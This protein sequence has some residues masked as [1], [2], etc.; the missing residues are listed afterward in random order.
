MSEIVNDTYAQFVR[1]TDDDDSISNNHIRATIDAGKGNDTIDNWLVVWDSGNSIYNS[2]RKPNYASIYGG[3][4]N[5]SIRNQSDLSMVLG[6]DGNDTIDNW[7][8]GEL[9]SNDFYM[10]RAVTIDGGKGNDLI[11]NGGVNVT[12]N[13]GDGK[14]T[15]DNNRMNAFINSD[16]GND[17]IVNSDWG[18]NSTLLGGKGNDFI[19]NYADNI[20][21]E[22]G[23]GNDTINIATKGSVI[24]E[25]T[26]ES[27]AKNTL[28]KYKSGDGNDKII[29]FNATSTLRIG[30]G[31][32]TYSTVMSGDNIVVTVGKGKITL[33]GAA[34]LDELHIDGATVQKVTNSTKSPVVADAD[35]K[36]IDAS[37]RL[38]DIQITA[39]KLA[40][41][42]VGG[43]KNDSIYGGYGADTISGGKGNDRLYG[44]AGNDSLIGGE[45][46]DFI[47]GGTGKDKLLGGKGND[48]LDG[49]TGND[50]IDGG[51]NADVLSGGA[52][53][54][55]L[56][57]GKGNDSLVGDAGKD[58][59]YG[60]D[61]DDTIRG[62]AGDD[63]LWGGKGNDF[64][65]GDAGKDTF[66][67]SSG[68]GKD[69]IYGFENND[70]LKITGTFST[71]YD[72]SK[73]E[74]YFKV[75]NTS[76][77]IMLKDFTATTFNVNSSTYQISG[78]KLVK[79]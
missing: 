20:T 73:H 21:I 25:R 77:A 79:K 7:A 46:D 61:G 57:G 70:L 10:G 16:A 11:I 31:K 27:D 26:L 54:D 66:I 49:G 67:Y 34:D 60:Q 3:A 2:H 30:D 28:I 65:Y 42:I 8:S 15:V 41:S 63:S 59:L 45:G 17:S 48:T 78:S 37:K 74:V 29:G 72:S 56:R 58:K 18:N 50:S 24:N 44:E 39:N 1:G 35:V 9:W 40:N 69:V 71:S 47:S 53:N 19:K 62:G 6:G 22:G 75:G 52:G 4:G 33:V 14:D 36:F 32:G 23:A 55:S 51:D 13:G 38:I 43:T 68:D 76:N 5:D 12:I 64:L